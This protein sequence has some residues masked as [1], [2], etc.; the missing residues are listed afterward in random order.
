MY[1]A[2]RPRTILGVAYAP[3]DVIP[4]EVFDALPRGSALIRS[5]LVD[6]KGDKNYDPTSVRASRAARAAKIEAAKAKV[7]EPA[8]PVAKKPTTKAA[9]KKAA[10]KPKT[11][12]PAKKVAS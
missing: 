9:A 5:G 11:L 7:V 2:R 3:G 8:P 1:V 6:Y 4:D 12:V 10:P